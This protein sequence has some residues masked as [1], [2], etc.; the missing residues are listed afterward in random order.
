M[1]EDN[2][3]HR[4]GQFVFLGGEE[5]VPTQAEGRILQFFPDRVESLRDM[6]RDFPEPLDA[7]PLL[8]ARSVRAHYAARMFNQAGILADQLLDWHGVDLPS[9]QY[10][11]AARC[12]LRHDPRERIEEHEEIVRFC[13]EPVGQVQLEA[14]PEPAQWARRLAMARFNLADEYEEAQRIPE[15]IG[16]FE[17]SLEGLDDVEMRIT[18]L[19]RLACLYAVVGEMATAKARFRLSKQLNPRIHE[20]RVERLRPYYTVIDM[21]V[22]SAGLEG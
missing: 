18:R 7:A 4:S 6:E 10:G 19:A 1:V 17:R 9:W 13:Q 15:A 2:G 12:I 20:K 22:E 5:A 16:E 3:A 21:L 14:E 11:A 8:L